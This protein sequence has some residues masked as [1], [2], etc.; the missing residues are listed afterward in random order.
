ME[1]MSISRREYNALQ[2]MA[3]QDLAE[4]IEQRKTA[5]S[6][7]RQHIRV[8]HADHKLGNKDALALLET[9]FANSDMTEDAESAILRAAMILES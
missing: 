7:L 4:Y 2:A 5:L 9:I 6:I 3:D 1:D 8:F